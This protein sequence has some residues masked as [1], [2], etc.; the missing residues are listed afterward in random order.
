M[1]LVNNASANLSMT[2][3]I[4]LGLLLLMSLAGGVFRGIILAL[5]VS[6]LFWIVLPLSFGAEVLFGFAHLFG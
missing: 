5:L 1:N 4:V 6:R 3:A 2:G